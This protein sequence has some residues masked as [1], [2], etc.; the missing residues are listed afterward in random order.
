MMAVQ[1]ESVP[2]I[3]RNDNKD[4]DRTMEIEDKPD[5]DDNQKLAGECMIIYK[6][7]RHYFNI[8]TYVLYFINR[9]Q[10]V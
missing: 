9:V 6:L 1:T 3:E 2:A 5:S 4:N 10:C 7:E 8:V